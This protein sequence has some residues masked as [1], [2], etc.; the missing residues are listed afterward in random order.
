M[1][2]FIYRVFDILNAV[3][4]PQSY[5]PSMSSKFKLTPWKLC[6]LINLK[7]LL[8]FVSWGLRNDQIFKR[9][10]LFVTFTYSPK[11]RRIPNKICEDTKKNF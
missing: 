3:N 6:S 4:E 10:G 11:V 8:I 1:K 7:Y 9:F 2:L 5:F